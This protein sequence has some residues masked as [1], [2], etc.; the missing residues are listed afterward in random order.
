MWQA[1]SYHPWS[2]QL[3]AASTSD[4][5]LSR[6]GICLSLTYTTW[7]PFNWPFGIT[8]AGA[9]FGVWPMAMQSMQPMGTDGLSQAIDEVIIDILK[10]SHFHYNCEAWMGNL[11]CTQDIQQI[12]GIANSQFI[13][14][15]IHFLRDFT[16]SN[17]NVKRRR[18]FFIQ[19]VTSVPPRPTVDPRRAPS[20]ESLEVESSESEAPEE[21][22][23]PWQRDEERRQKSIF[24]ILF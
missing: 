17:I 24:Q 7:I 18:G 15:C 21:S 4:L 2:S 12:Q 8:K 10:A 1:G 11:P 9:P 22:Q 16:L 23:E 14:I 13:L 5:S 19:K 20:P 3:A 6:D